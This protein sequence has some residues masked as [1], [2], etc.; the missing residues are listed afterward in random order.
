MN[1]DDKQDIERVLWWVVGVVMGGLIV[2]AGL[3]AVRHH[4]DV[5]ALSTTPSTATATAPAATS[6]ATRPPFTSTPTSTATAPATADLA[7]GALGQ[8][9]TPDKIAQDQTAITIILEAQGIHQQW[10]T[11]LEQNPGTPSP[12][13]GDV[14][15]QQE[16][17]AKYDQVL[18]PLRAELDACAAGGLTR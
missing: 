14:A 2:W 1:D 17:V 13:T 16:W 9:C 15:W 18:A 3:V 11:Y 5:K 7:S 6:T 12:H 10:I 4:L 8:L